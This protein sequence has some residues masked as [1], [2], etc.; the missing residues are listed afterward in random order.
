MHR[1]AGAKN[2]YGCRRVE[3]DVGPR[4]GGR[5]QSEGS[6][7]TLPLFAT[8]TASRRTKPPSG[9]C[10]ASSM[11]CRQPPPMPGV[12]ADYPAP[13]IRYSGGEREMTVMRWG[14][15]P[16]PRTGGP[17]VTNI[18][19]VPSELCV[20]PEPSPNRALETRHRWE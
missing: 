17:P 16:P 14:V 2:R 9:R 1:D 5:G 7:V 8:S 18:R 15:P 3:S 12:F 6:A 4:R 10:S 13:V 20:Q 19:N 11:V